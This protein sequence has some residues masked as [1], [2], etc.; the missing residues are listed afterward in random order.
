MIFLGKARLFSLFLMSR[1]VVKFCIGGDVI[2]A[3]EYIQDP[4]SI[5]SSGGLYRM[6]FFSPNGSANR[7]VGIWYSNVPTN[8]ILWVANRKNPILD[9]SGVMTI[10]GDGNLVVV[11]GKRELVWSSNIS[12]SVNDAKAQLSDSGNLVLLKQSSNSSANGAET[13]WESFQHMTDSF[14]AKM[15]LSTNSRTN[16]K[17][18]LT[19]WK[20]PSDPSI[21][22][23]LASLD[24]RGIPELFIWNG[25]SLY[26]RSGPWN[27]NIFIGAPEMQSLYIDGFNLVDNHEGTVTYSFAEASSLSYLLL[28]SNGDLVQPYLDQNSSSWGIAWS[29]RGSD[30]D[31]Y[32]QCGPFGI[33]NAKKS[34]ICSCLR[35]FEPKHLEEW[36]RGNWSSGCVRKSLLQ[37]NG[38]TN[39][40]SK[41]SKK[42]GFFKLEL[43]K[44]PNYGIWTDDDCQ[45]NCFSNCSCVAYAYDSG[46]GC[47]YWS[48]DLIDLQKFS[49]GGTTLYVRLAHSE[50]EKK[51]YLRE[52]I[53][54]TV[55]IGTLIVIITIWFARR[56]AKK[57][58]KESK[59]IYLSN[60][61]APLVVSSE[62]M[63]GENLSRV[64]FQEFVLYKIEELA[65]AT[66]N[67]DDANKLGRGGFGPVYKGTLPNGQ[68]I[69]IKR[70]SRASGQGQQEFV[71]EMVVI[72]KV[73]HRNL[74][75]LL[76]C[77]VEGDE[78]ML[79]YEFMP[80]KS[81]DTFLFDP[82]KQV[83]LDWRTRFNIIDGICRGLLYLHRDSRLRI[84]HRDMKASN[85]L[86]DEELN[87]KISDFG[88]A[89]I[90]GANENQ[91]NTRR[92]VGTYGYMAPEY[93]MEGRFSEKLDV[94][95]FGI[96]L[97][98]IISGR[99]NTSFYEEDQFLSLLGQA[100]QL[101]NE[102]D[103]LALVDPNIPVRCFKVELLRCINVGLLCTQ[104]RA[105]DRPS[106]STVISMINGE[107]VDLPRPRQPAFTA[108]K[109][110][111]DTDSSGQ[112]QKTCSANDVTLTVL[113]GR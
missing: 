8:N 40:S 72:C 23:F 83:H 111:Q 42:D 107:I 28:K 91:A 25:S 66:G 94:F 41:A 87:P 17:K 110:T 12:N 32:G 20:S 95:S 79:I 38:T 56:K 80:N 5:T 44:V 88:M 101:W 52:I 24:T 61:E 48:G 6:G 39:G 86:L 92:V 21:G 34:P 90:F 14:L 82:V 75:R 10:S 108:R 30:C 7:Y 84:I 78:K 9:S 15:K 62:E 93:A 76:G 59:E 97:L 47:M 102:D 4:G 106:I 35:G 60:G 65:A 81:L 36:S 29:S 67:F 26:W 22:S 64:K 70:L 74:V 51:R 85:I 57:Q 103:T 63:L 11:N 77:C 49:V 19:S 33:C 43:M 45:G 98:E 100:W 55:I 71:N 2:T 54:T 104:E 109:I 68:E 69:A 27:G 58:V 31:V 18:A 53:A 73:Q 112:S 16:E 96:L 13:L 1:Y 89:R 37:C 50:L 99:R 113:Q 3:T 46:V 105:K